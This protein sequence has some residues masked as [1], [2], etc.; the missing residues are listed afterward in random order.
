MTLR[1]FESDDLDQINRVL[2][3]FPE[4]EEVVRASKQISSRVHYPVANA[5]EL[6]EALGGDEATLTFQGR[7]YRVGDL[8]LMVP[9]YYF[10]IGNEDDL[11]AKLADLRTHGSMPSASEPDELD[12]VWGEQLERLPEGVT[13]PEFDPEQIPPARGVAGI[14]GWEAAPDEPTATHVEPT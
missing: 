12:V 10:P 6:V 11:I 14:F 8:R 2:R 4:V 13:R 5:N 9:A 3:H 7:P 1:P